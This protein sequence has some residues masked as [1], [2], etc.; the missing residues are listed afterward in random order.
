LVA[1]VP[2]IFFFSTAAF[3]Q[4][5]RSWDG[6]WIGLQGKQSAPIQVSI[7]DGKV[8]SYT[9]KGSAFE[10]QYSTVTPAAVTF[11]DRDHYFVKLKRTGDA[12]AIG[13][14]RGRLGTGQISLSKQQADAAAARPGG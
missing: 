8:A 2:A 4:S 5:E 3:A 12:T 7:A 13:K 10:V 9:L 14:I 6:T 1:A 11:G